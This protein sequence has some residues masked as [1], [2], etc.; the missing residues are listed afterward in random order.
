ML[1]FIIIERYTMLEEAKQQDETIFEEVQPYMLAIMPRLSFNYASLSLGLL[2]L[3]LIGLQLLARIVPLSTANATLFVASLF[4][5]IYGW[6]FLENRNHATSLFVLYTRYSRQ[7][8]DL[9]ALI[10]SDADEE[11]LSNNIQWLEEAAQA[12]IHAAQDSGLAPVEVNK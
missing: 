8:R 9:K 1:W 11:S 6:R 7:R 4:I 12:F 3:W 5:F 10:S 2:F